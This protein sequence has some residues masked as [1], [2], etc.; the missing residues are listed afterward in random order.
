MAEQRSRTKGG[1]P[2]TEHRKDGS[3]IKHVTGERGD[4]II[5]GSNNVI[6]KAAGPEL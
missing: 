2:Q 1:T 5:V 4:V 3:R 6:R